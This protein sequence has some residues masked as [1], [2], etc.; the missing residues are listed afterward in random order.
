MMPAIVI[1][2]VC[3]TAAMLIVVLAVIDPQWVVARET[4]VRVVLTKT[5]GATDTD[6][7][8][9][10]SALSD[11]F[12]VESV[13]SPATSIRV[14]VGR[15]APAAPD[16]GLTFVVAPD[17]PG[18]A[19]EIRAVTVA[20][21]SSLDAVGRVFVTLAVPAQSTAT[22]LVLSLLADG[23][24]V[25]TITEPVGPAAGS[26]VKTLSFIPSRV[27]LARLRVSAQLG[28]GPA[29]YA[30]SSTE[31]V[32]RTLRVLFYDA[33]PSWAATFLRRTLEEDPRLDVV[34]RSMTSRGVAADAGAP[35]ASL[36]RLE[37]LAP[38]DLVVVSTPEAL[39]ERAAA[40]LEAYLRDREGAVV[41]VPGDQTAP[42]LSR[43]TGVTSWTNDRRPTLEKVVAPAGSWTASEFLWP[44]AFP[45][46]AEALTGCVSPGRCAVWRVPLGGGRVIVSSALDGWRTRGAEASA[47]AAFWRS[48]VGDHATATPRPIEIALQSRT[49]VPDGM[50]SAQIEALSTA[51]TLRAE[52]QNT[53]GAVQPVRLWPH[54]GAYAAEFR[55]PAAPGR[56]RLV[57][58]GAG[59]EARA[60]FMVV[61]AGQLSEPSPSSLERLAAFASSR[62][63]SVVAL[64]EV[65]TLPA[66]LSAAAPSTLR[67]TPANPM[68]SPW[69][70]LP[71]A[72]LL[73]TEWWSRRR[74]GAR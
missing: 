9:V 21:E 12:V 4:P 66:R 39:P 74:R 50:V 57:V 2:R 38:F 73:A 25:E 27:G 60:E 11:S 46:G 41:L 63:G 37:D 44:G 71:F 7:E 10:K 19:P 55:A 49:V 31:V 30:D 45:Q 43:L 48:V 58:T 53:E 61:D 32:R 36:D 42:V 69:W 64:S 18:N 5:A 54:S 70:M 24:P 34:V 62:G 3:R 67:D 15:T 23:V 68:R 29:S 56:Y 28:D 52:W 47:F 1:E 17:A 72:G 16:N 59:A 22:P 6:L 35:P 33:R 51:G 14:V 65:E 26:V 40:A 20:D 8:R 13:A